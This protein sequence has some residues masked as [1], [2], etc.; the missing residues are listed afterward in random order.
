MYSTA[1]LFLFGLLQITSASPLVARAE[2]E[3]LQ[4][5]P[6]QGCHQLAQGCGIT[7]EQLIAYNPKDSLC[8]TLRIGQRVC[9]TPGDLPPIRNN[10]DG[11]CKEVTLTAG[12]DCDKTAAACGVSLPELHNFNNKTQFELCSNLK[13]G[14]RVCCS[15]GFL[16]S[17]I[18]HPSPEDD[19]DCTSYVVRKGDT[20]ST[21]ATSFGLGSWE[22]LEDF[23]VDTWG[24]RGCE[25]LETGISICVNAGRPPLPASDP[26]AECGPL[27]PGTTR[28]DDGTPLRDL[29]PCPK[30]LCCSRWGY[31]GKTADH[32]R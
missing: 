18:D 9:C 26:N 12:M 21:L 8:T 14:Q 4:I 2:C 23:N 32:C 29:N 7:S 24:W 6:N 28:P 5:Q 10:P 25:G 13:A 22:L 19:R 17:K 31:C 11:S 27:V 20:C 30:S 1:G 15:P 16:S 3:V